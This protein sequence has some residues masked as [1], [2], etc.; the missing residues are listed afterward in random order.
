MQSFINAYFTSKKLAE[1]IK[2]IKKD[3]MLHFIFNEKFIC[4]LITYDVENGEFVLQIPF[5][6]KIG[7][8]EN[9]NKDLCE[10]ILRQLYKVR[11]LNKALKII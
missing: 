3:S 5:F 8:K 10:N 6:P 4:V 11:D 2:K 7:K 9:Y 1:K